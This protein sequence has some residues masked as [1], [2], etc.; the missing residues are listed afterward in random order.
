MKKKYTSDEWK[1]IQIEILEEMGKNGLYG[2]SLPWA[3]EKF[4]WAGGKNLFNNL[5]EKYGMKLW[6]YTENSYIG[7]LALKNGAEQLIK[8]VPPF[9]GVSELDPVYTETVLEMIKKY[10]TDYKD[11]KFVDFYK[12]RD[13]PF[14]NTLKQ[15]SLTKNP[16][17]A[18][19]KKV[20]KEIRVKYGF[21]KYGLPDVFSS[22]YY[23]DLNENKFK[24]IAF[25]R[26]ATD[27]FVSQ[28]IKIDKTL[29]SIVPNASYE[30]CNF[31]F[32]LGI[33]FID[34]AA[35]RNSDLD[36]ISC[37]PYASYVENFNYRGTYNHGFGTK[38]IKDLTNCKNI[39]TIIQAFPYGGYT[40]DGRDIIEWS[41]QALKNGAT[42]IEF[43]D[44]GRP[45][46]Y[47]PDIYAAMLKV[48][49]LL[50]SMRKIKFPEADTAI[51]YS[52]YSHVAE[53]IRTNANEI[54]TA[55]AILGEKIGSW[56]D[57]ISDTM[58]EKENLNLSKYKIIYIPRFEITSNKIFNKL[59][60]YV[61]NGGCI[62]IGDPRALSYN[63]EGDELK[64]LKQKWYGAYK[65]EKAKVDFDPLGR[66]VYIKI[67]G[68]QYPIFK[69]YLINGERIDDT[70]YLHPA[71]EVIG[72]YEDGKIAV[73][74]RK[75]G[76]GVLY[77]WG[78]NPFVSDTINENNW[79]E[80]WREVQKERGC[81]IDLPIWNF[82]LE[83]IEN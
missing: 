12:G 60:D 69:R 32:I 2:P 59:D 66:G 76:N 19:L 24:W 83:N 54:Y 41:S 82:Y 16:Y 47:Q 80:F 42:A 68:K 75:H 17:S 73:L 21:G 37:D 26:W 81:K 25:G 71:G 15:F 50:K 34:F 36:W 56:F 11:L 74:K 61:K 55:Y 13:E 31:N 29:H 44:S 7:E 67:N 77:L 39:K 3:F 27:T 79:I 70:Y 4:E 58:I 64:D 1:K 28:R 45:K 5:Y 9:R 38:L 8:N 6:V 48:G 23:K 62:V 18:F 53:G 33:D 57:F 30:P 51:L 63:L 40:P 46:F 22:E 43:Y 14:N 52:Y 49:S 65:M 10:A 35:F 72:K 20:D 78:C